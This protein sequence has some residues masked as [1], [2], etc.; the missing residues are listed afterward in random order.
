MTD[1]EERLATRDAQVGVIGLGYV[2]LPLSLAFVEAGFDV[3]GFDINEE[4]VD[5]LQ[6]G[7]SYVDD[8]T[9]ADLK[10]G[11]TDGFTPDSNPDVVADCD[12]YIIAVPTGV[13]DGEPAM[14]AV[15]AAAQT[16]SE[17]SGYRETLV[18]VS[19]TVYPG[20]TQEVVKPIIT[21]ERPPALTQFAMVPERLNPGGD[22][23]I[24]E[25]PLVVGADDAPARTA[26]STLFGAITDTV[27][28]A[29]TETAELSKT[30]ENT[31][32][33][34]NIALVNQLVALTER[35]DADVWEAVDAA[36]SKP[37][38]FQAFEPGPG[39][40]GHCIPIDPQFLTWRANEL[41]T[42]LPFIDHAQQVNEEMPDRVVEGVIT[43][44]KARG[45]T[46]T[47]ASV[48][49][50]GAAYKPNI[51]DPRNSPAIEVVKS[52]R[53]QTNVTLVDPHVDSEEARIPLTNTV[54]DE[55]VQAADAVVL[56]VD[57]DAF[58]LTRL[59]NQ[60]SFVYDAKN[61][62]PEDASATVVTLG[63][64]AEAADVLAKSRVIK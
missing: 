49:A 26:A 59:G 43:A 9:D 28:V 5:Q 35:L 13:A 24:S 12:V 31:Y 36:G 33:M 22:H 6:A 62:M 4:R 52:L 41:G 16:V 58:N 37:F 17:Q 30:L 53:Q 63:E 46:L 57:H 60:A 18:V 25:I 10:N 7:A 39:V 11:L 44:L 19:S 51:T 42:E 45:V 64:T 40:G 27:P 32:R 23:E 14:G 56:L 8:V 15:R 1:I 3:R 38:G 2:G 34:V 48:L 54:S 50:L 61:A 21:D 47:D 29:A 55:T 20:A